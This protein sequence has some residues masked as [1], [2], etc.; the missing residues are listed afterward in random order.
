MRMIVTSTTLNNFLNILIESINH[1]ILEAKNESIDANSSVI[2]V[3]DSI[4]V[5]LKCS[6]SYDKD[7]SIMI[8]PSNAFVSNYYDKGKDSLI[9]VRLDPII[10]SSHGKA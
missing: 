7:N 1:A 3:A 2:F 9:R 6:I 8:T 5:N 4:D 10:V